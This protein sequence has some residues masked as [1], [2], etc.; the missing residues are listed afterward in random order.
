MMAYQAKLGKRPA[1]Q[2][3][4]TFRMVQIS[5]CHLSASA[6]TLYRGETPDAGLEALSHRIAAWQPQL[7][8][9]TGDL[10]EDAS[11]ASYQRLADCLEPVG[12]PVCALPG[13]HDDKALMQQY[14]PCG[15]WNGPLS[16]TAGDW[17]LILLDSACAG[18]IDGVIS[19][20]NLQDVL[21]M[22]ETRPGQPVLLALHHHPIAAGSAWIDR[23]MLE[24]PGPLLKLI[25]DHDWI[26]GVVWGHV[27]QAYGS[28]CGRARMLACPSTA[29]N[30]LPDTPR[31][32][33][34][35]AGPACRWLQLRT[36]GTL[37]SGLLLAGS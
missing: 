28:R 10:S 17:R 11:I 26:R 19:E 3:S 35:P 29:A 24:S 1:E 30:S 8:L 2:A 18:R 20:K 12:A 23:H 27:H 22:L 21:H 13:N 16:L 6:D 4:R 31:F 14:F 36:G 9:A 37:E 33:L 25:E 5:D 34:D 15:P 32:E 7:V